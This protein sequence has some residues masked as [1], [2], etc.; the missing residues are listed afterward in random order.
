MKIKKNWLKSLGVNDA[1]VEQYL[2][3]LKSVLPQYDID[4]PLRL[5]HFLSQILH[6][7]GKMCFVEENLNYSAKGLRAIFSKYFTPAQAQAYAR[8]KKK[9]GSR[10]YANRMGNGDE[11]SGEG[12]RYRG[13]G[14][15]QLTG[16][17][18]YKKFSRWIEQDVVAQPDLVASQFA[19]HSA[20][21]F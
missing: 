9:I 18:N 14:L 20:V 12:Y 6:E 4:T 8:K 7:S 21:Y 17:N 15:I 5:A 2:P 16:K 10:V 19:V 3:D 1:R 11:E 13:R